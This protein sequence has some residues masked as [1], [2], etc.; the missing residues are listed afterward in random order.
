[1][2]DSFNADRYD[3]LPESSDPELVVTDGATSGIEPD[4]SPPRASD[5]PTPPPSPIPP[6]PEVRRS[7]ALVC[8]CDG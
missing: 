5:T 7:I 1:M 8:F 4:E 3:E 2:N 6:N